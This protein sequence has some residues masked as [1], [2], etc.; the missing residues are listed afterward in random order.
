[1]NAGV[2]A[3]VPAGGATDAVRGGKRGQELPETGKVDRRIRIV[4]KG[5]NESLKNELNFT[6]NFERLVLGCIDA[7]VCK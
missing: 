1:M 5:A 7:D 2:A 4:I 6:P 3:V